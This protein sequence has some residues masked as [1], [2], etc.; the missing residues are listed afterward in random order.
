[1]QKRG[2]LL[3]L[4]VSVLVF[5]LF[6][7]VVFAKQVD[8]TSYCDVALESC[9]AQ[10]QALE[11]LVQKYPHDLR[12]DYV[13]YFDTSDVQSSLAQIALECANKQSKKDV[14]KA[15]LQNNLDIITRASLKEYA[16]NVGLASA[17]FSFCLD[18]QAT[19]WDVLDQVEE[20]EADGVT[21]APSVRFNMDIYPGSQTFTSLH[22]LAKEY[23]GLDAL[24]A[25][26]ETTEETVS[27]VDEA[28]EVAEEEAEPSVDLEETYNGAPETAGTAEEGQEALD[29]I[30]QPLFFRVISQVR[31]WLLGVFGS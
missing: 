6:S 16:D 25:S 21:S 22:T 27:D 2:L 26:E 24:D 30:E 8:I 14:Y 4:I 19:A 12:V 11:L 3:S 18:T 17:N 29:Q 1:M 10:D 13:Y 28:E 9:A 20:A 31:N 7:S 15:E 23:L 5:S